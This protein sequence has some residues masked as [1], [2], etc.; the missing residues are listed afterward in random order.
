MSPHVKL[1]VLFM[2][3]ADQMGEI[4]F[5]VQRN[6]ILNKISGRQYGKNN[7]HERTKEQYTTFE[8]IL[9]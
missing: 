4:V 6:T 1:M 7:L 9:F 3:P 8:K 2:L 5:V